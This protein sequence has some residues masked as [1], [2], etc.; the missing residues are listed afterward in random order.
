MQA[1]TALW[2]WDPDAAATLSLTAEIDA[3]VGGDGRSLTNRHGVLSARGSRLQVQDALVVPVAFS[4]TNRLANAFGFGFGFG[5]GFEMLC[6][7]GFET[8][9][10]HL[11]KQG[12]R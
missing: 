10:K 1:I 6:P 7:E 5:F 12:Y 8:G 2:Q 11:H 3:A 4:T 9:A